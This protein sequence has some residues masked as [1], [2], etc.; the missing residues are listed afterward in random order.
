M[1]APAL[2]QR[3]ARGRETWRREGEPFDPGRHEVAILDELD[4]KAFVCRHHYSGSYPAARVRVG[5]FRTSSGARR[6]IAGVAV[7]SVPMQPASVP[8]W[9]S[10]PAGAGVELG[11]FVLLDEVEAN[12]ETWFLRRAFAALR[13]ARPEIRAVLSYSDPLPRADGAGRMITPGHVGTIYQAYNGRYVG[14]TKPETLIL[15]RDGRVIP[16]RALSKLKH[17]ERGAGYVYARLRTAGAPARHLL[18]SGPAYVLRAL[19]EGPFRRIRHPGNHAYVWPLGS[20]RERA[21]LLTGFAPA[22]PYPKKTT[23]I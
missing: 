1:S 10:L 20:A 13:D 21:A 12:G 4:A 16:R 17:D 11:R 15:D 6:E 9:T 8:R 22:R 3:W 5:L 2:C 7:F 19:Q 23:G 14:C 18:E